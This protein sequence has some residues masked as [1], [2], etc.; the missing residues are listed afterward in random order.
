MEYGGN[1]WN[2]VEYVI[3]N[4][5]SLSGK[6]TNSAKQYYDKLQAPKKLTKQSIWNSPTCINSLLFYSNKS[7][8]FIPKLTDP[9]RSLSS[10][11]G[12]LT[13]V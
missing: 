2:F 3:S 6:A 10:D 13:K 12:N 5:S 8:V 11:P 7:I 1:Y 4:G 9:A